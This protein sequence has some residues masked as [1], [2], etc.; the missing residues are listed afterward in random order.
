MACKRAEFGVCHTNGRIYVVGG[1]ART[2]VQAFFANTSS[3]ECYSRKN[4]TW[5][6][7]SHMSTARRGLALAVHGHFI[8]AMGGN[9]LDRLNTVEIYDTLLDIWHPGLPMLEA[10]QYFA[11]GCVNDHIYA[12]G[13]DSVDNPTMERLDIKNQVWESMGP[14]PANVFP[15]SMCFATRLDRL[16]QKD[17]DVETMKSASK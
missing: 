7:L 12:I 6:T 16:Q 15:R 13:G 4:K 1:S 8:Y 3:V 11:A 2:P 10:R 17:T 5:K 14:L 9:Q